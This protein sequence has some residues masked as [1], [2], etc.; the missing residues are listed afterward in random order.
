MNHLAKIKQPH[1]II[2]IF[3]C[4]ISKTVSE[5]HPGGN[6]Y[7]DYGNGVYGFTIPVPKEREKN[8]QTGIS[9][10]YLYSDGEI[11]SPVNESGRR[12]FLGTEFKR[13]SMLHNEDSRLTLCKPNGKGKIRYWKIMEVKRFMIRKI[14]ITWRR[15]MNLQRL[16][17]VGS[18]T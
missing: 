14:I 9:I 6:S 8:G 17:K 12:L 4:D 16:S 13:K 15:R 11:K 10:E 7:K 2:G 1:K 3:D 18:F 5:M